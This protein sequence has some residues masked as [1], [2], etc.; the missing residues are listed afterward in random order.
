MIE[1]TNANMAWG[2]INMSTI[3]DSNGNISDRGLIALA[4]YE[5]CSFK[6][7]LCSAGVKTIGLG[8]TRSDI[9][10]L[11]SWPWEKEISLIQVVDIY[12]KGLE[13]YVK[14]V[15]DAITAPQNPAQFDALVS[16]CYN[17]GTGGFS[18]SSVVRAVN[19]LAGD[20]EVCRCIKMWNK[21]S[22]KFVKRV[23][24]GLV[25]RRQAE[26]NLYSKGLYV[27]NIALIDV[28]HLHRPIYTNKTVDLMPFL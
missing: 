23:V 25:N 5:G 11:P 19:S 3:R 1:K 14:A 26:C 2:C 13:K 12:K 9:K 4:S 27:N 28:D 10:D 18:K 7:Y 16:L 17:I 22:G 24:Q 8:S 15:N 20:A 6:A 21:A